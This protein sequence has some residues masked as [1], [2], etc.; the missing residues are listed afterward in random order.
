MFDYSFHKVIYNYIKGIGKMLLGV[1]KSLLALTVVTG[2][3]LTG[4]NEASPD[5]K[6]TNPTQNIVKPDAPIGPIANDDLDQFGWSWSHNFSDKQFY[7]IKVPNQPWS[8]VN[9]NPHQLVIDGVYA[10]G[11]IQIR[12]KADSSKNRAASD[13]LVNASIYTASSSVNRPKS[14]TRPVLNDSLNTFDWD[15]V[16]GFNEVSDYEY[17]LTGGVNW[18][19]V[20]NKPLLVGDVDIDVGHVQ[21]R[22]KEN[23]ADGTVAGSV[24]ISTQAFTAGVPVVIA[25]PTAPVIANA[26]IGNTN[27]PYEV[28]TN[29]FSWGWVTNSNTGADYDEPEQYEFTNDGGMTWQAVTSRP[30][31]IGPKAYV[32]NKVGVRVKKNAIA[33][34]INPA[35]QTLYATG[36]SADFYVTRV[37]SMKSWNQPQDLTSYGG[38]S[39][40]KD[41]GCYIEYDAKGENPQFWAYAGGSSSADK[42]PA[43][44]N[45]EFCGMSSW[46]MLDI[47][48]TSAKTLVDSSYI[49][50]SFDDYLITN[51]TS[52]GDV[53]WAV[54]TAG[55]AKTWKK[56]QAGKEITGSF[57]SAKVILNWALPDTVKIVTESASTDADIKALV[58]L[59]N[60]NWQ[61]TSTDLIAV[62]NKISALAGQPLTP[63]L[64]EVA[65]VESE[66]KAVFDLLTL[67][68]VEYQE[69]I[70]VLKLYSTMLESDNSVDNALKTTINTNI[71][72]AKIAFINL[73]AL[74]TSFKSAL[75]VIPALTSLI[76]LTDQNTTAN[77]AK[78]AL[79]A[80]NDGADIHAKSL[81]LFAATAAITDFINANIKLTNDLNTA[82][83]E[84]PTVNNSALISALEKLIIMFSNLPT[85]ADVKALDDHAL[86]GLKR[87]A[88][89]GYKALAGDAVIGTHFAK[90]D[91]NGDYLPS[92]T[93]YAQ[94]WR[95]V[96]DNRDPIGKRI[97][98]LLKDGLPKGTDDLAFDASSAGIASVMGAGGLIELTNNAQLC[99]RSDWVLPSQG[100]LISLETG[101]VK[102]SATIDTDVFPHHL[103]RNPE[104][105]T[106]RWLSGSLPET[107]FW[108]WAAEERNSNE[109]KTYHYKTVNNAASIGSESKQ[110]D[111]DEVVLARLVSEIKLSY[112]LLDSAGVATT[113]I[114][115]A[116]CAYQPDTKLTWQLFNTDTS[117]VRY[118]IFAD[119]VTEVSTLNSSAL[120]GKDNWRV[121]ESTELTKLSPIDK[122]VFRFNDAGDA[123]IYRCYIANE[124][125][126]HGRQLCYNTTSENMGDMNTFSSSLYRLVS[127]DK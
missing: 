107:K 18:T 57:T 12:V 111:E 96:L 100:Q 61:T 45:K 55:D 113:D 2:T 69:K 23:T 68:L 82:I 86:A 105:D 106:D 103:A 81:D 72:S 62:I 36:A 30:Q 13:V 124:M 59:Q 1:N 34:Q 3:L 53:Y 10:V 104:Y 76:K 125:N 115:A 56:I 95:C 91:I 40:A 70:D 83:N 20:T 37:V 32:K 112:Q 65:T 89:A 108:Y 31:H 117:N 39:K 123:G 122:N 116:A 94:G 110:G 48:A 11:D 99:G 52:Y 22:V 54:E 6:S 71:D 102:S 90:L 120:C 27:Y 85:A 44:L 9:G 109:Q 51:S 50:D 84:L 38:W 58:S 35:G 64:S 118:K 8:A 66:A 121:P 75:T 97:W 4:C 25:A 49:S 15:L 63:L 16:S 60:G 7:E 33:N 73:T 41:N 88:V 14:P 19:T 87:A 80:A 42:V 43:L 127:S 114:D 74:H 77:S 29:G 26:N 78:D 21:V 5:Q 28:K 79:I 67:G 17:S 101:T 47:V 46:Q 98:A 24:L 119:V 126:Q 93:T 92:A